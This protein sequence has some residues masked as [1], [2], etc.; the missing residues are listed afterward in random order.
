MNRNSKVFAKFNIK[1]ALKTNNNIYNL[2]RIKQHFSSD[3]KTDV[4]EYH[5]ITMIVSISVKLAG[6]SWNGTKNIRQRTIMI[7]INVIVYAI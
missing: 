5:A 1:F 6:L 7:R 2:L 4:I 3:G